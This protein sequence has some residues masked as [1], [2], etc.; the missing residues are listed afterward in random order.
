MK[1]VQIIVTRE[2]Y[3][4]KTNKSRLLDNDGNIW[5]GTRAEAIKLIDELYNSIYYLSHNEACRP[6]Y[7][8]TYNIKK[9]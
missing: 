5:D 6:S 3:G 8:I 4:C 2:F 9:Y 7:S 1:K